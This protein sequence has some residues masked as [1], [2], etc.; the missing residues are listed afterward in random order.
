MKGELMRAH[1]L[2]ID[3]TQLK[4]LQSRKSELNKCG[5]AA[6]SAKDTLNQKLSLSVRNAL[7]GFDPQDA[8]RPGISIGFFK[9]H[10]VQSE[11]ICFLQSN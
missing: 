8:P 5:F 9:G 4:S 1:S 2:H 7:R 11:T 3:H 6:Y 10:Y